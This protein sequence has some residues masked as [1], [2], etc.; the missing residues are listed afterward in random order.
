MYCFENVVYRSVYVVRCH[1]VQCWFFRPIHTQAP[2]LLFPTDESR[3]AC[4]PACLPAKNTT[5]PHFRNFTRTRVYC[6]VW[7]E[8]TFVWW[9]CLQRHIYSIVPDGAA[10]YVRD[11]KND[12]HLCNSCPSAPFSSLSRSIPRAI[13]LT[14]PNPFTIIVLANSDSSSVCTQSKNICLQ[15]LHNFETAEWNTVTQCWQ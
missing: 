14:H 13:P 12:C 11:T 3:P 5:E 2:R 1:V 10:W 15:C 6:N 4:L 8:T 7:C 9:F